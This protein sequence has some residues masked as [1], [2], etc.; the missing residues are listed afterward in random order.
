MK[1]TMIKKT[2]IKFYVRWLC[3][4][5]KAVDISSDG[6]YPGAMLS[7]FTPYEFTFRG[8]RFLSMES[9]LQ[10][11]KFETVETQNGVFERVGVKAKLRGKKRKWYLD[12]RLYW[13]GIPMKRDSTEYQ[14][15][16]KEAFEALS[17]NKDFQKALLATGDKTLYH[18]MGKT[19][20]TRTILTEEEFCEILTDIRKKLKTKV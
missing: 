8:K 6:R 17:Q 13:Q 18:T 7:N 3:M 15:L 19:D 5:G 14:S 20:P 1:V 2:M 4:I 9:L 12:Q 16:V 11:L 10:G